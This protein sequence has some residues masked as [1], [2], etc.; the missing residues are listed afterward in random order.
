MSFRR[1]L[2]LVGT[3]FAASALAQ[4][5]STPATVTAAEEP[6]A[7]AVTELTDAHGPTVPGNVEA[8]Q[9][10]SA[11]CAAC[12]GMDGN[13]AD[14]QYPKLAG[15]HERYIARH[16]G[17]FK[18]G[19]RNNAIMLG[20][21]ATLSPQDMR[22]IGAFYAGQNALPGMADD[23]LISEG[24]H[25]GKKFY[26]VGETLYR[27]GD[28][29]RNIPACT[30]C[31]GIAGSGNPGPPYPRLAGQH[32]PYTVAQLT[33]FRDGAAH[34]KGDNENIVMAGVA[35]YLTDQE[36]ASLASYIEGLHFQSGTAGSK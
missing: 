12:H 30:G 35:K 2:G 18:S 9:S 7:A 26:Q 34:G 27:Q 13:A 19:E 33:A 29:S 6:A 5:E 3:L 21:A 8:G 25:A 32:A 22:D 20:F 11:V 28:A 36:I 23:S 10:K 14:P 16:L 31:H 1:T 24:E 17:L 4:S 15:Q